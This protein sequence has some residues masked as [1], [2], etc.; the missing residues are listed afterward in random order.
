[1]LIWLY[2]DAP[3]GKSLE[4]FLILSRARSF[5]G[6]I[7]PSFFL[8][9]PFVSGID[10]SHHIQFLA[11]AVPF[12]VHCYRLFPGSGKAVRS[13]QYMAAGHDRSGAEKGAFAADVLE[14]YFDH[15]PGQVGCGVAS[16]DIQSGRRIL[17]H[18]PAFRRLDR[19]TVLIGFGAYRG[20]AAGSIRFVLHG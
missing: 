6:C 17:A 2:E 18:D 13:C 12:G 4:A 7:V 10:F 1:M 14:H 20:Y 19:V 9:F 15:S 3:Y 5:P 16:Q 11:Y 8:K